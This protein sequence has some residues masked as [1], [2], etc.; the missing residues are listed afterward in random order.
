MND[1]N[2]E[3]PEASP[4]PHCGQPLSHP[5]LGG[6]CPACLLAQGAADSVTEGARPPFSPPSVDELSPLFPQLEILALAGKGGMGA[7][8]K[9]RQKELDRIVALKIL[10]LE[11]G[12]AAGFAERFAREAKALAKL[13]HANI[14]TLYEFG[15]TDGLFF[16]LM[17]FV[18]GVNLRQ[19][20]HTGRISAREA[21]AIVP[22]ICDALQYA[23]DQGI[24]HRDIKPENILLDRRGR[25]KVADFGLAKLMESSE[26]AAEAETDFTAPSLTEAGKIMGTPSYMAPEQREAPGDVDHRADIYALGVV[27]YQMLTGELPGQT[28]EP[29]SKKV[30]IDVR[31]DE[32]VLRALE[33]HPQRRY[34][35]ASVLK[36]QVETVALESQKPEAGN[37]KPASGHATLLKSER[38]RISIQ[39]FPGAALKHPAVGGL[40]LHSDRLVISLG[41]DQRA[42][43]LG[44]VRG[45]GETMMPWWFSPAGHCYA[46]VEF[47]ENGQRRTLSF[48]PGTAPFRTVA[49]SRSQSAEWMLAIQ[50]AAQSAT[51]TSLSIN[52]APRVMPVQSA[53]KLVWLVLP[54]FVGSLLLTTTLAFVP[55]SRPTPLTW[56]LPLLV[57]L[58]ILAWR[59]SRVNVLK[60]QVETAASAGGGPPS[61]E[62]RPQTRGHQLLGA[63]F[64]IAGICALVNAGIFGGKALDGGPA[65]N[66]IKTLLWLIG[67]IGFV[68]A[69]GRNFSAAKPGSSDQKNSWQSQ[70]PASERRNE[71]RHRALTYGFVVSL[72]GLPIGLVLNLPVVWGLSLAGIIIGSFKS[73]RDHQ[74]GVEGNG[75]QGGLANHNIGA[76]WIQAACFAAALFFF[77]IGIWK[78][79]QFDLKPHELFFG[80]LLVCILALMAVTLGL[81]AR[82]HN[83]GSQTEASLPAIPRQPWPLNVVAALFILSGCSSIWQMV[84]DWGLVIY[85]ISLGTLN[86]PIGIGLLRHRPWWRLAA[87]GQLWFAFIIG[88]ILVMAMLSGKINFLDNATATIFGK[89]IEGAA[90]KPV[91]LM[92]AA[93]AIALLVWIYRVLTR[94]S[95]RDLFQQRGWNRPWLEWAAFAGMLAMMAASTALLPDQPDSVSVRDSQPVF[96]SNRWE[97]TLEA[98][99]RHGQNAFLDLDQPK[100]LARPGNYASLSRAQ[101]ES[102][103]RENGIDLMV[104]GNESQPW[105]LLTPVYNEIK[106]TPVLAESWRQDFDPNWKSSAPKKGEALQFID[107]DLR[108]IQFELENGRHPAHPDNTYF[109]QT[110]NGASGLLRI[111]GLLFAED[112]ANIG[113]KLEGKIFS[114]SSQAHRSGPAAGNGP[115]AISAS[116][117]AFAARLPDGSFVELVSLMYGPGSNP[118]RTQGEASTLID[119]WKPDGTPNTEYGRWSFGPSTLSSARDPELEYRGIVARWG[120]PEENNVRLLGWQIDDNK[121]DAAD[122]QFAVTPKGESAENWVGLM[123]G[124]PRD[125]KTATIRF[126]LASGPYISGPSPNVIWATTAQTPFGSFSIGPVFDQNGTAAV[127]LTHHLKGCDYR[128]VT[129]MPEPRKPKSFFGGLLWEWQQESR[130]GSQFLPAFGQLAAGKGGAFNQTW[131]FPGIPAKNQPRIWLEV[132]PVQWVEFRNVALN[133]GEQT[134]LRIEARAPDPLKPIPAEAAA[135]FHEWEAL[136][137]T[138]T[139]REFTNPEVAQKA[140]ALLQRLA[141]LLRG[142]EAEPLWQQMEEAGQEARRAHSSGND[143]ESQRLMQTVETL[144]DR[145]REMILR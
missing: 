125:Q 43:P 58:P 45:L 101:K 52:P 122:G 105:K 25:V 15:R 95:V 106:L 135:V 80:V 132:R 16:F 36:T 119:F 142:T 110:A 57:L 145:L 84:S 117:A 75:P 109:F 32:I 88:V 46:G 67:C 60:T 12:E 143:A 56:I 27:F 68:I 42:I 20:L 9:A 62:S 131:E 41:S 97:I 112:G 39:E 49:D 24:V 128:L 66:A 8:Y 100:V 48:L 111:S 91:A 69:G 85:H 47:D 61:E 133:P 121:K 4:C 98:L 123:Q 102:W 63:L 137:R 53:W 134:E 124:F 96:S 55:G 19:L 77:I 23:H 54:V 13:N 120:G 44:D 51:G 30:Q 34:G 11:I 116:N 93:L 114:S 104:T 108:L 1:A 59:F 130:R 26:T 17:E 83:E 21:L 99:D 79:P 138:K 65:H 103:L 129:T 90:A 136:L 73:K 140:E 107:H 33:K 89:N 38:G 113:L 40:A 76:R 18:D 115:Q 14:V 64:L 70:P 50:Q 144:G 29:P 3:M 5:A 35:Q 127:T 118:R 10:P 92:A 31:L 2:P 7:V 22:Q 141:G 82:P 74:S 139:P 81:L 126:A 28:I 6:L 87:L 78:L 86:L 71:K 94:P 37:R 72:V